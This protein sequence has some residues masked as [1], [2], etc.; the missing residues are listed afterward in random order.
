MLTKKHL[1]D[2]NISYGSVSIYYKILSKM[3][4]KTT[5]VLKMLYKTSLQK[6]SETKSNAD[7]NCI[8]LIR[9]IYLTIRFVGGTNSSSDPVLYVD[10]PNQ[11]VAILQRKERFRSLAKV[12]LN[13]AVLLQDVRKQC[14]TS[15]FFFR[16]VKC[17]IKPLAVLWESHFHLL[18]TVKILQKT[19]MRLYIYVNYFI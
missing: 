6:Q 13:R 18:M 10:G 15:Q 8:E 11:S 16:Y 7:T 5:F 17:H 2:P 1:T 9:R 14:T 12:K 4:N 19:H 3:L